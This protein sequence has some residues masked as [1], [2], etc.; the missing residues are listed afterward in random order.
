MVKNSFSLHSW[1]SVGVPIMSSHVLYFFLIA[2]SALSLSNVPVS[3][4]CVS[5]IVFYSCCPVPL[6]CLQLSS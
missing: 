4:S 1:Y 3:C 6:H 5:F 2:S